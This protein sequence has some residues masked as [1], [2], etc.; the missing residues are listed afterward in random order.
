[1][2]FP[3][4]SRNTDPDTSHQAEAELTATGKRQK[5][6]DAVLEAVTAYPGATAVE[7]SK[8][9]GIDRYAVSRRTADL[10]YKQLIRK[11]LKRTCTINKRL[12]VTWYRS[13]PKQGELI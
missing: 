9:S 8:W 5:Q 4:A 13:D 7:L 3:Q 2:T 1:M 6:C 12:M 11:G 10:E